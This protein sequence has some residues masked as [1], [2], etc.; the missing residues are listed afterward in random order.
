MSATCTPLFDV[1]DASSPYLPLLTW[2]HIH[3]L[4]DDKNSEP[5]GFRSQHAFLKISPLLPLPLALLHLRNQR[6]VDTKRIIANPNPTQPPSPVA[7]RSLLRVF[8]YCP[9]CEVHLY[10]PPP[11]RPPCRV[12]SSALSL[13]H[14]HALHAEMSADREVYGCIFLFLYRSSTSLSLSSLHL[15][16]SAPLTLI[17]LA[18]AYMRTP[19]WFCCLQIMLLNRPTS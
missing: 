12:S 7:L 1:D 2:Y 5:S 14:R 4:T 19:T 10:R 16:N 13:E 15:A 8:H 11:C 17:S 18:L 9:W 3:L 6:G